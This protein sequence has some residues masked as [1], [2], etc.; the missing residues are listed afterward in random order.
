MTTWEAEARLKIAIEQIM[1]VVEDGVEGD[2]YFD[3]LKLQRIASEIGAARESLVIAAPR[4][5]DTVVYFATEVR[6]ALDA[7]RPNENFNVCVH[8]DDAMA[9][10]EAMGM[11]GGDDGR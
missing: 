7:S 6:K 2:A 4:L 1:A 8:V 9:L 11:E 10:L 3:A 5:D